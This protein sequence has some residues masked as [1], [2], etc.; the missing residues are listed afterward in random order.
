[1]VIFLLL[2]IVGLLLIII[3]MLGALQNHW[4][5]MN[6]ALKIAAETQQMDEAIKNIVAKAITYGVNDEVGAA[7]AHAE[8]V[9]RQVHRG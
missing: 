6:E 8:V 9:M 2:V 5:E 3:T 1:M 7:I 4:K